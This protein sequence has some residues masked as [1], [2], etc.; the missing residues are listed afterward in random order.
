MEAVVATSGRDRAQYLLRR[1][2]E[3]ARRFR[4]LPPGPLTTDYVNT[5]STDEEPAFPGDEMMEKRIRRI[6]RWNAVAMVHRANVR[7]PGH[8]RPPLDLRLERQ[9]VRDRLQPLLPRKGARGQRR[10]SDLLPG[11]R[12]ARH[13]RARLSR[14][15]T[16]ASRR[17]SASGARSE[18]GA[19]ALELPAPA[20][21]ARLL[22]VPDGQHGARPAAGDL[23]GALRSLPRAI[24]ASPTPA[25]RG[26][27]RSS[28]TARPTSR[29]RSA[30]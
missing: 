24:A 29:R 18:R 21:D 2:L 8:R 12:R 7:L 17:W 15:A 26:S 22:G 25:S 3:N 16:V 1:V 13:L 4:I 23:P 19:G 5:I 30:A 11:T 14:R 10:R 6:V 28:A 9:P 27:G 20:A